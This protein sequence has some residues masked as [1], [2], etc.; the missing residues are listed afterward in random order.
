MLPTE[1]QQGAMAGHVQY[2]IDEFRKSYRDLPGLKHEKGPLWNRTLES[3]LLHFRVL[4]EFFLCEGTN[5]ESDVHAIHYISTCAPTKDTIFD[6]TRKAVNKVL[7]HL[8][9]ER[10]TEPTM[11][12]WSELDRMAAATETLISEFR[13]SLSATQVVWFHQLEESKPAFFLGPEDNSTVSF[14]RSE[15]SSQMI[16]FDDLT[17]LPIKA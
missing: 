5:R 7:A 12:N 6:S 16:L 2:E 13:K 15:P 11:L 17:Y 9:L 4:R 14:S 1:Q 3:F 10:V 8:T